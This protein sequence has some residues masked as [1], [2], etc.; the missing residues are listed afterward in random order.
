[1]SEDMLNYISQE[2]SRL[3]YGRIII[4]VIESHQH[5]DIVTENRQRFYKNSEEFDKE[6]K[7][8]YEKLEN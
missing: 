1:M 6:S 4:E 3:K 2:V 5:I 7:K 8:F